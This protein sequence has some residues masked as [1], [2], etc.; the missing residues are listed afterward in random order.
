MKNYLIILIFIS[1][2]SLSCAGENSS[3]TQENPLNIDTW[4]QQ[5]S[6]LAI[7][8]ELAHVIW[9]EELSKFIA[10]GRDT[11]STSPEGVNWTSKKLSDAGRGLT[12]VTYNNTQKKLVA[13][14][15]WGAIVT[16]FDSITWNEQ[17]SIT[18]ITLTSVTCSDD[19]YVAVGSDTESHGAIFT[20]S[21]G[22]TWSQKTL[23][24]ESETLNQVIWNGSQFAAVGGAGAIFTSP[25]GTDWTK[26]TS[27]MI[28]TTPSGAVPALFPSIS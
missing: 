18:G 11:V 3:T 20:S 19:L 10:V 12:A 25:D 6:G 8:E 13:I 28:S 4:T 23:P 21:N 2:L 9:C 14:G 15:Y 7:S 27:G 17:T 24:E 22:E 26:R 16:S 1:L 5:V